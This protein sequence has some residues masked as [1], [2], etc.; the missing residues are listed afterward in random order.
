MHAPPYI[1]QYVNAS[2]NRGS[3][4]VRYIDM[5]PGATLLGE[6]STFVAPANQVTTDNRFEK[7]GRAM[8]NMGT[9]LGVTL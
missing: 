7:L 6:G 1:T 4:P 2:G 3:F 5:P 8:V 9:M